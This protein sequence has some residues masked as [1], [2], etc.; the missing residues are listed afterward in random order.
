LT[1]IIGDHADDQAT[2]DTYAE[3]LRTVQDQLRRVGQR[4]PILD[5]A[6]GQVEEA[7]DVGLAELGISVQGKLLRS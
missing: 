4:A 7:R 5:A 1:T 6:M 2:L 3:G